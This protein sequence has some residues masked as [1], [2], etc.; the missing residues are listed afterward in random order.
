MTLAINNNTKGKRFEN[1][2]G[3]VT[4]TLAYEING[5]TIT[6]THTFVPKEIASSGIGGAL[7]EA[8]LRFAETSGFKVVSRCTFVTAYIQAHPEF[9]KLLR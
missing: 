6:F 7:A 8:A 3:G 1:H 9:K 5:D 2:F 4:S